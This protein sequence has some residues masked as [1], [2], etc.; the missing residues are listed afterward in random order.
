MKGDLQR[1]DVGVAG[2]ECRAG[3][4]ESAGDD[5]SGHASHALSV[6]SR[7]PSL[8]RGMTESTHPGESH[9]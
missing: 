1:G 5:R 9:V 7:P 6:G 4:E 2:A 8:K 3:E